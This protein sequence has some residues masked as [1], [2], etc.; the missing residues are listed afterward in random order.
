MQDTWKCR[1]DLEVRSQLLD[2][3]KSISE[4]EVTGYYWVDPANKDAYLSVD[5]LTSPV[6]QPS[7]Y[8]D[9]EVQE[10]SKAREK[11]HCLTVINRFDLLRQWLKVCDKQHSCMQHRR[12]IVPKRVI[13]VGTDHSDQLELQLS[14]NITHP[15]EYITLSHCWGTPTDEEKERF[16]TTSQNH[17]KRLKGFSYHS[18]PKVFQD[19]ITVTRELNKQYLWIDALCIIQGD[20]KDWEEEGTRMDNVFASAY[21]TIASSSASSWNDGFLNR[22]EVFSQSEAVSSDQ[23]IVDDFCKL[24]DEGQLQKRAWVLQERVLSRR[25]IYFTAQQTYWEC[26]EGVRCENFSILSCPLTRSFLLD[27]QFPTRLLF[28]GHRSIALF[29]QELITDYSRRDLTFP[30]KDKVVA[31]SGIAERIKKA[32][33][34]EIR[35]GVF[36]CFLPRLLLWK[37]AGMENDQIFHDNDHV[38]SWSWML[39]HDKIDFL[40]QSDLQVPKHQSLSF[41]NSER[42][43]NIEVRQFEDCYTRER[44]GEY[45]IFTDTKGV[46]VTKEVEVG[47]LHFDMGSAAEV[48]SRNCVVI[49]VSEDDDEDDPNKEYYI[50]AVQKKWGEEE[51]K[52]LGVGRVRAGYVSKESTSGKLL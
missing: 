40:I 36:C 10:E 44:D 33:S 27:P 41:D 28:S 32:L 26:G 43:I 22:T 7:N 6:I 1:H 31:F 16:C 15:F 34:T 5:R 29:L 3:S 24:V 35:Y 23:K 30:K 42:G 52:R 9:N 48:E 18:L 25:T 47:I 4:R 17:P 2:H 51:Y 49:A 45:I 21:C 11:F 38:P 13:Y 8:P 12:Q 14:A 50:L 20:Q 39:Y 37:R 19:A 46:E